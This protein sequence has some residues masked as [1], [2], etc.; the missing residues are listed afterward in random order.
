MEDVKDRLRK[1]RVAR[2]YKTQKDFCTAMDLSL[3][4]YGAHERGFRVAKPKTLDYYA[5]LLEVDAQWLETGVLGKLPDKVNDELMIKA[6]QA[7]GE[8]VQQRGLD[9]SGQE[10][11]SVLTG[12]FYIAMVKEHLCANSTDLSPGYVDS[13]LSHLNLLKAKETES[14]H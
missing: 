4:T 10:V 5:E 11:R 13:I 8:V 1:A 3:A 2:G 9:S 7:A 14:T 6:S 12:H